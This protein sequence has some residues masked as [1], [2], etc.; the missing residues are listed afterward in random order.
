[1]YTP[2][3]SEM[4]RRKWMLRL[5]ALSF[6]VALGLLAVLVGLVGCSP[7]QNADASEDVD[8]TTWIDDSDIALADEV[9]LNAGKILKDNNM[10]NPWTP[11]TFIFES[12]KEGQTT[13]N[14]Y[15]ILCKYC[16]EVNFLPAQKTRQPCATCGRMIKNDPTPG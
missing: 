12:E 3:R 6:S 10:E 11:K 8:T 14:L 7:S 15:Y 2:T 1:M 5:A 4:H 16:D 9:Y 13:I